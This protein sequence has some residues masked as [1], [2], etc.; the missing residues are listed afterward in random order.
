M[1]RIKLDP[2]AGKPLAAALVLAVAECF[3]V[4]NAVMVSS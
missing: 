1:A 4:L 3:W 2:F